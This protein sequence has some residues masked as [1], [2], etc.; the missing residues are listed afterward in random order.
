M[1]YEQ[2][3]IA[4]EFE[5]PR[6]WPML[7]V[8]AVVVVGIGLAVWGLW[9]RRDPLR[10]LIAVDVEGFWWDGSRLSAEIDDQLAPRL[11]RL[12]FEPVPMDDPKLLARLKGANSAEEAA[13]DAK[14]SFI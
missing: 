9:F 11:K 12:G 7:V 1:S 3:R 14:A 6:S 2:S 13:R 8:L 10:T 4:E 5:R